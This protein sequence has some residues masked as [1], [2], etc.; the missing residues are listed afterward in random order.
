MKPGWRSRFM[1]AS[2]FLFTAQL[3]V[4]AQEIPAGLWAGTWVANSSKSKFPG[5][6]PRL[7]QVTIQPDGSVAIHVIS[8]DGKTTDW[9]YKP[10]LGRFVPIQGRDVTVKIVRVN[11]YRLDQIWNSKGTLSKSHATLS[12]DGKTQIFYGVPGKDKDGKAFQ[13]VVVYEKQ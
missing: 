13:E 6:A 7:D 4:V 11:D 2:L 3:S 12:K 9:S 1:A 8:A 5:T 10:Q